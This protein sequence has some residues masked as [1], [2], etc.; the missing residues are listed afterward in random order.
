VFEEG[1]KPVFVECYPIFL[2]HLHELFRRLEGRLAVGQGEAVVGADVLAD[3]AAIHPALEAIGVLPFEAALIFDGEVGE[4]FACVD[5][6]GFVKG[7]GGAGIEAFRAS[8]AVV[9]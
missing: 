8:A 6:E 5:V 2:P 3:V 9:R 4:A 1:L 7:S